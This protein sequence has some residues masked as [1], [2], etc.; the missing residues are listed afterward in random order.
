MNGH[1]SFICYSK[2]TGTN[3]NVHQYLDKLRY[4]CTVEYYSVIKS[5]EVLI[6][7]TTWMSFKIITPSGK[8]QT[9]NWMYFIIQFMSRCKRNANSAFGSDGYI[10][11]LELDVGFMGT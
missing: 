7:V 5:T 1:S 4:I 11:H 2:K 6:H 8:K 10:Y 3:T 9:I